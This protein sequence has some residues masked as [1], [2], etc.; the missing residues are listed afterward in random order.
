MEI[1]FSNTVSAE[2]VG[3]QCNRPRRSVVCP[4]RGLQMRERGAVCSVKKTAVFNEEETTTTP[5]IRDDEA[6]AS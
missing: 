4:H 6:A 3:A 2:D 1:F 5:S